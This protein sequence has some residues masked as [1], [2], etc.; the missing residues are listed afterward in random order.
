MRHGSGLATY[1]DDNF[2]YAKRI[3]LS[4]ATL[5]GEVQESTR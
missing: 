1:P 3:L 5:D 2:S 4:K